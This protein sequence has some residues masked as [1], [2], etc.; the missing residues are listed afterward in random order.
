[1]AFLR[2]IVDV[3]R[4]RVI[5]YLALEG[6][7]RITAHTDD[8]RHLVQHSVNVA[9]NMPEGCEFLIETN[10]DGSANPFTR[11]AP[12]PASDWFPPLP[13]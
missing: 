12:I 9:L 13:I 5:T 2:E 6:K 10:P 8:T 1:M 11:V 3:D 7:S 4:A